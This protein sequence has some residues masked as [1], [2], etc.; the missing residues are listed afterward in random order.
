MQKMPFLSL[1]RHLFPIRGGN[2]RLTNAVEVITI[3]CICEK[4]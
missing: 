1:K 2:Y 4:R 3:C